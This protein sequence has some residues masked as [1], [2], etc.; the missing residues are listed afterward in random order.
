V[1][2]IV[3]GTMYVVGPHPNEL[4]AL[5]ATTGD[6]KWVLTPPTS[7]SVLGV[8]CC[9]TGEEV[10]HTKLGDINLGET[11]TMAPHPGA[12]RCSRISSPAA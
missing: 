7:P 3:D 8:A 11:M 12:S 9:D 10:W 4:F 2:L 6:R 1:P 5:E